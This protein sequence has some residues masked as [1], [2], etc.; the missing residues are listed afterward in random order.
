LI[1]WSNATI[2]REAEQIATVLPMIPMAIGAAISEGGGEAL[3]DLVN[4]LRG[5]KSEHERESDE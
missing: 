1:F 2:D 3:M 5:Q 4:Q